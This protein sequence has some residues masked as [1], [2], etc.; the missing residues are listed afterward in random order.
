VPAGRWALFDVALLAAAALVF[1]PPWNLRVMSSGPAIYRNFFVEMPRGKSLADVLR[2][3][4]VLYYRDGP[5]ATV[6][7]TRDGDILSLR[8]NGKADASNT[9]GDV[10]TQF[11]LGHLPLLLHP[12]P[13][14]VL[15]IGLGSGITAGAVARYPIERLDVVEIEPAVVGASRFF[16][17][18][19]GDV[20]RD[21]RVHL[22]IADGRNFL[23]TT[24]EG[25]D[26]IVSEPSNPWIGG[27][28]SLFSLEFYEIARR[29]LRPGG[30]MV[31]W[32]E[33]YGRATEDLRMVVRTFGAVF[34][35]A[36]VWHLTPGDYLL[37]G[38]MAPGPLDLGVTRA[39]YGIPAVAGDLERIG[40]RDWP[41]VP[42]GLHAGRRRREPVRG[43]RRA[44]H[45]RPA[46]PRVLR[47]ARALPR[48]PR[49]ELEA[50]EAVQDG[51]AAGPHAGQPEGCRHRAGPLHDRDRLP[52]PSGPARRPR[53][54]PAGAGAGPDP[55]P[56]RD[57]GRPGL[58]QARPSHRGAR[59][60]PAGART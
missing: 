10:P 34:P 55:Q 31:Q 39:Q 50:A 43:G 15:V 37:L 17:G 44:Q 8:V 59:V 18:F 40:I 45:R 30:M 51:R 20:L 49:P 26:V 36:T 11:M 27:V 56:G 32:V 16:T 41:G 33:A 23:R 12:D 5:S 38:R 7:V 58:A 4:E 22:V 9:I 6:S 13:R 2:E 28:A 35:G 53:S 48:H 47:A 1:A 21:P 42:G 29:H 52:R 46:A 19:S 3:R 24:P 60:R 54:L 57:P 14:R 25:Y